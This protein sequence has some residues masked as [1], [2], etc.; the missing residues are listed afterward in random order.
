MERVTK[1]LSVPIWEKY[2]L[3]VEEATIYFGIGEK[4]L[5]RFLKEHADEDFLISNGVKTLVKRQAFANYL[6]EKVTAL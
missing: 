6:D 2:A 1:N 4:V 3:T 5:R